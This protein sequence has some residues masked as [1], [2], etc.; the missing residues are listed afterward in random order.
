MTDVIPENPTPEQK[1]NYERL[2][3]IMSAWHKEYA[4]SIG[5][6]NNWIKDLMKGRIN[7]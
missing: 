3:E 6:N 7:D 2:K 5:R 1:A 4:K